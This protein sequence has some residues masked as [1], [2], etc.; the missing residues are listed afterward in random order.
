MPN[1]HLPYSVIM[2]QAAVRGLEPT[3]SGKSISCTSPAI[4]CTWRDRSVPSAASPQWGTLSRRKPTRRK[5]CSR[6]R[7]EGCPGP[8]TPSRRFGPLARGLTAEIRVILLTQSTFVTNIVRICCSL[9]CNYLSFGRTATDEWTNR[10]PL[11][12]RGSS[13][14]WPVRA[15]FDDASPHSLLH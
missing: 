6:F 10:W 7:S 12:K 11:A 4:P 8:L 5:V 9:P 14:T 2:G 1:W 3:S 15:P 13:H